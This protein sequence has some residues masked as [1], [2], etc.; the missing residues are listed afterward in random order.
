MN[1]H[2]VS[3]FTIRFTKDSFSWGQNTRENTIPSYTHLIQKSSDAKDDL[4]GSKTDRHKM[5]I[6]FNQTPTPTHIYIKREGERKR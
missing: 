6:L 1:H 5:S 3:H 2:C 4:N